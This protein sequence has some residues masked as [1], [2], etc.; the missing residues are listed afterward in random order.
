[1]ASQ[2]QS[3][4]RPDP[5][6]RFAASEHFI[7]L[8]KVKSALLSEPSGAEQGHRHETLFKTRTLTVATFIFE[9]DGALKDHVTKGVVVIQVVSG[10]IAVKTPRQT[11]EM[12]P[13]AVLVLRPNIHHAITASERSQMLLTV[14]L[15]G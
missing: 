8:Q 10:R 11:Y 5:N 2:D 13:G 12:S 7:D 1:M 3:Q 4:P 15:S 14:D 6:E 9:K